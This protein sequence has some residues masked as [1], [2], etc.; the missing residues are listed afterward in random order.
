MITI[1][2]M[3]KK[4]QKE[5]KTANTVNTANTTSTTNTTKVAKIETY[6]DTVKKGKNYKY[7]F[8][9]NKPVPNFSSVVSLP[10]KMENDL[11]ERKIYAST[12][13]IVLPESMKWINI[14]LND[15]ATMEGVV[16]FLRLY[17]LI[18]VKKKFK[19]DYTSEFIRW[20]LGKSGMMIAIVTKEHNNICGVIGATFKNVTVFDKT[21]KF[22]TVD[23]LCAHPTYR[24]KK[25]A[26]T[27]I[28]EITRRIVQMGVQQ[29]CFTTER[30]VP[31]PSSVIRYYHRP[32]NY[33][34]LQKFGFTDVGGKP[35]VVQ[36][37]LKISGEISQS[38]QKLDNCHMPEVR[39][40]YKKYTNRFSVC[41]NYTDQ[42]LEELL[43]NKFVKS[44]VVVEDNKVI[45][46]FSYYILPYFMDGQAE[47][48]NTA[49][50]FLY[51]CENYPGGSMIDNL[52]KILTNDGFDLLN[53]NDTG[54]MSDI[55]LTKNLNIDEDSDFESYEHVYEQRFLK[56]SG[57]LYL[58]FFNWKCPQVRSRR[59]LW[60]T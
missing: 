27:L 14:N 12:E 23:F 10:G 5:K 4:T 8:W 59:V 54:S 57:K 21:E 9:A 22:G 34:K 46:F 11:L 20:T 28:D 40:L 7:N 55:L 51:S 31:S 17:Y 47:K 36:Q 33:I 58:N 6:P 49:Y 32:I 56:G 60:V 50:L 3:S 16:K 52:L 42:E 41:C 43:I 44:Y 24:G 37:K 35:E 38:I 29:G 2:I 1:L 25:I 15:D 18:D 39:L 19:L 26:Y 53:V 30:C 48:I 13:S 45:D